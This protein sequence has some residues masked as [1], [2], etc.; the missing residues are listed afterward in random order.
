LV[1]PEV[2]KK[3]G[4]SGVQPTVAEVLDCRVPLGLVEPVARARCLVEEVEEAATSAAV[5]EVQT[6]TLVAPMPV[7]EEEA[8]PLPTRIWFQMWFTPRASGQAQA[9][10]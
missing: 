2:L 8:L 1:E 4:E 9:K 6:P 3:L 10:Q 7:A 5:E